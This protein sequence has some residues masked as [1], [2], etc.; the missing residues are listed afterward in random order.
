[1]YMSVLWETG[2]GL[3]CFESNSV[4]NGPICVDSVENGPICLDSVE[5][6]T[7]CCTG[8]DN[9]EEFLGHGGG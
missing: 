4:G 3:A 1:M 2:E 7:I 6:G 9:A 5:N 8:R